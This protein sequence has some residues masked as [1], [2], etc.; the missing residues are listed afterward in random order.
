MTRLCSLRSTLK[1]KRTS[2]LSLSFVRISRWMSWWG[3]ERDW[4]SW[5]HNATWCSWSRL[6]NIC[7]ETRSSTESTFSLLTG[8]VWSLAICFWMTACSSRLET[9]D[10]LP[11]CSSREKRRE[12]FAGLLTILLLKS[13]M[14]RLATAMKWTIGLLASSFIPYS[15]GGLL[16]SHLR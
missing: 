3:G 10:W 9:S 11:R 2:I 7:I 12:L 14:R 15:S 4:L 8:L 16:L 6:L 13:W 5:K 1:T